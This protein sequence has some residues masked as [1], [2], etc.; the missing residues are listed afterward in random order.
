MHT[1]N[2]I[3]NT[4]LFILSVSYSWQLLPLGFAQMGATYPCGRE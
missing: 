4:V 1:Y 3:P 2:D